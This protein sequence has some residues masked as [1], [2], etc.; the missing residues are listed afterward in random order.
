VN[1]NALVYSGSVVQPTHRDY[2]NDGTHIWQIED[3]QS[4]SFE[5]VWKFVVRKM[6]V[7]RGTKGTVLIEGL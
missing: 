5:G 6:S 4:D 3:I 2:I 1:Q 7:E